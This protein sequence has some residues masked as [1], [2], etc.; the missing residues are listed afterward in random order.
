L[1]L[2]FD[3]PQGPVSI[4][5]PGLFLWLLPIEEADPDENFG[6]VA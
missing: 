2:L 6:L 1:V 4:A 3:E 5:T